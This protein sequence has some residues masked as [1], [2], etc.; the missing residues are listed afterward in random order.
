MAKKINITRNFNHDSNARNDE[1][2]LA[3]R[4]RLGVEGYGIYFMI[5]E[6]L[7]ENSDYMSVKDYNI[8]AF[9]FRTSADKVKAVIEEFGLFIFTENGKHF[10]SESLLKRMAIKDV[11]S[12]KRSEAGKLGNQAR[13]NKNENT[14]EI[15]QKNTLENQSVIAKVS[16]CDEKVSQC[17][18]NAIA[19]VSQQKEI[20]KEKENSPPHPPYKE[21]EINKEKVKPTA[22]VLPHTHTHTHTRTHEEEN[23]SKKN[24]IEILEIPENEIEIL[25]T[26]K[27]PFQKSCEKKVFPK[28]DEFSKNL[29]NWQENY[30]NTKR[31]EEIC[32]THGK[33]KQDL[34]QLLND[35]IQEQEQSREHADKISIVFLEQSL[36]KHFFHWVKKKK[37]LKSTMTKK[38]EDSDFYKQFNAGIPLSK[39]LG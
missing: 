13:W 9:D 2:I 12:K 3:M 11:K 35:F 32:I 10:Y 1:K 4:M 15:T 38:E 20:N 29:L 6:R 27:I 31:F 25:E 7:M 37:K 21:K 39:I 14:T 19:N 5:L 33:T 26:E 16:Q 36:E 18:C 24:E 8:L 22:C 17:D 28:S 34:E 30:K 23:F